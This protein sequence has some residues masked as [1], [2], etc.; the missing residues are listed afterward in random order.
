MR[1]FKWVLILLVMI[2][3][4]ACASSGGAKP[5]STAQNACEAVE[6]GSGFGEASRADAQT[7]C[8]TVDACRF[9]SPLSCV[10]PSDG[11]CVCA[12]SDAR[13]VPM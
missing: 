6:M 12:G 2:T 4:H 13:C 3:L 5:A 1:Y 7:L 9:I 10:C 8:Q 11:A